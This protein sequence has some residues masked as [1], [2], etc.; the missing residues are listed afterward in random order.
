MKLQ[1]IDL[2]NPDNFLDA[3]P[4]HWLN[5]IRET[6]P[7]YWHDEKDGPGFWCITKHSD[8][9]YVSMNPQLFSSER[10]GTN[11]FEL[12]EEE[13][14]K[15]RVIMLNM[16]PPHHVK[17]RRIVQRGFTPH[18]IAAQRSHIETLAKQ[19]VD[20]VAPRGE[21]EFVAD[22]ASEL[23]LQ[24]ICELMGVPL[25]DRHM[26]Y[27]LTNRM[28]GFDDPELQTSEEDG[29]I[30]S[31]QIFG[32]GMKL[33]ELYKSSPPDTNLVTKL[34]HAQID[35]E[36]LSELEFCSFFLLLLIAGN[37]TTRTVTTHGMR[38]LIEHPDQL[39]KL[40]ENPAL[41]SQA[42][43]EILRYEP[44][45]IHFRRT[46][47]Q[48]L[49]LRGKQIRQGDKVIMWYHAANR[50]PEVFERP[51]EFD[52]TREDNRHV[53]FGKGEHYCLGANLARLELNAIF[54]EIIRRLKNPKLAAPPRRMRGNFVNG[55]KEMRIS[56]TPEISR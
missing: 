9:Q 56:F 3:V 29:Q 32:Y 54:G 45:V 37:E 51:D 46:A 27:A 11:M 12:S 31:A 26:I 21:C 52:V 28:I 1:H 34:V 50:D 40:T 23:P 4:V 48:D 16:D 2:T 36:K 6:D 19:I 18:T 42:V 20:K 22:L 25:E 24:V 14:Q 47:T 41:V 44:A 10:R 55:V 38:L 30:A 53:S 15:T 39:T 33:V 17:F 49:E 7:V 13:L 43:E 8:L 35:G 5:E